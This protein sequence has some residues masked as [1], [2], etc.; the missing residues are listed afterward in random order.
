MLSLVI[1]ISIS[2]FSL[3]SELSDKI[4][5]DNT[6]SQKHDMKRWYNMKIRTLGIMCLHNG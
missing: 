5:K 2:T 3:S 4:I 1:T 6:L